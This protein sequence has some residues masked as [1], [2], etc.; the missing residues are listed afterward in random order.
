MEGE[1]IHHITRGMTY[2]GRGP[3]VIQ[4]MVGN[5]YAVAVSLADDGGGIVH[6]DAG[7][8]DATPDDSVIH[9]RAWS[10]L[11]VFLARLAALGPLAGARG[12]L[13]G[14]A[15]VLKILPMKEHSLISDSWVT[16]LSEALFAHGVSVRRVVVQGSLARRVSLSLADGHVEVTPVGR[17]AGSAEAR[18]TVVSG[19]RVSV[20]DEPQR[21]ALCSGAARKVTVNIGCMCVD[22]SP[23]Q[24]V[25]L[26]GS[27]VGVALYDSTSRTGGLA[28]VMLPRANGRA[29]HHSRFAD[30]AVPALVEAMTNAGAARSRLEAKIA[31]GASVMF[32]DEPSQFH[33]IAEENVVLVRDALREANIPLM[34]E[35]VGGDVGRKMVVDLGT[36]GVRVTP[37]SGARSD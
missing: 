36:F 35:D 19:P 28:H 8:S 34:G 17:P 3:M 31:G 12:E 20:R 6:I 25:T 10:L 9:E 26:L 16:A 24:L 11:N 4:T 15:D 37:L 2:V 13:I 23:T 32:R 27:C 33:R 22:R 14:G 1:R 30:T 18:T 21:G 29:G 7:T 5:G